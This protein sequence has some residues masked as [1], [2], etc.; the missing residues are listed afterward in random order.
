MANDKI[1]NPKTN[2]FVSVNGLIGKK[3]MA[4][5]TKRQALKMTHYE[6]VDDC[7]TLD[8]FIL[9]AKMLWNK[10]AR[11]ISLGSCR[12]RVLRHVRVCQNSC[13]VQDYE[14]GSC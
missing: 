6:S 5:I 2:R 10:H 14:S 4:S 9:F 8:E 11:V 12:T 13:C 7:D 3:I 1:I